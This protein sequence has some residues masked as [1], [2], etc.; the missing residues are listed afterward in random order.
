MTTPTN[1]P[2]K[3]TAAKKPTAKK[4]TTVPPPA[5]TSSSTTALDA[6]T[7]EPAAQQVREISIDLIDPHPD[8]PRTDLGDLTELVDS[9]KAHGIRQNLVLVPHP[10]TPGRYRAVIGHRRRA[11]AEL[12]DLT[13][14][15]AVVDADLDARAQLELMLLENIQ[16]SDLTVIE[17]AN[18]YQG[19]LDLGA[20]LTQIA[21]QVGR[22]KTT[23]E[24]RVALLTL[25]KDAQEKVATHQAS[26]ADVAALAEFDDLP[27]EQE[28]L[29]RLLGT[30][31]FD[32]EL[33][34]AR[35]RAK[36]ERAARELVARL[37]ELS[38]IPRG[39]DGWL[40]HTGLQQVG[41]VDLAS[42]ADADD[43]DEAL[44][45]ALDA[46]RGP[47]AGADDTWR[48]NMCSGAL[49]VWRP[50]VDPPET[51]SSAQPLAPEPTPEELERRREA[52]ALAEFVR[53]ATESRRDFVQEAA[54]R[55]R[56][57]AEHTSRLLDELATA[58]IDGFDLY[59]FDAA[60]VLGLGDDS[61]ARAA[62][63]A[64]YSEG[65]SVTPLLRGEGYTAQG[66]ALA[67][68]S[69]YY[70]SY[71]KYEHYWSAASRDVRALAAI[72]AWYDLLRFLGY[73]ISPEE[74]TRLAV[75][76]AA[77]DAATAPADEEV[78]S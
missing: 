62:I 44:T 73:R 64:A 10:D 22:S 39:E 20:T 67:V 68:V 58:F 16:R 70:E 38:A 36:Y 49:T 65:E 63:E 19:L 28:R 53:T 59:D 12:A 42:I 60:D 18:G 3:K 17:E 14:V 48:W 52:A 1:A 13:T 43:S 41:W 77:I 46:A 45:E 33:R 37:P 78:A 50:R 71:A 9:I 23:V 35:T 6:I 31:S 55:K 32:W 54:R 15:P 25:P 26:L 8:N 40:G 7:A 34:N 27:D 56:W 11:A 21:R 74:E 75:V 47:L 66:L 69:Y 61:T 57:S 5:A 4:R 30:S 24:S 2:A 29:T 51:T 76:G 72:L